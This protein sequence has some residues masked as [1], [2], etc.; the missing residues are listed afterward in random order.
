[1]TR[2]QKAWAALDRAQEDLDDAEQHG[3]SSQVIEDLREKRDQ[4]KEYA[5]HGVFDEVNAD[6]V[7][8]R[9]RIA[10]RE[11]QPSPKDRHYQRQDPASYRPMCAALEGD[12]LVISTTPFNGGA[13]EKPPAWFRAL[14]PRRNR[15]KRRK[16]RGVHR[17]RSNKRRGSKST[18]GSPDD[19]DPEPPGGL[20]GLIGCGVPMCIVVVPAES[21]A[22]DA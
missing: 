10:E 20:E 15:P 11:S 8:R 7:A 16:S 19:P 5:E 6:M 17:G 21:E 1:M 22:D 3:L 2:F 18:R 4:A 12:T 14:M 13:R 9:K